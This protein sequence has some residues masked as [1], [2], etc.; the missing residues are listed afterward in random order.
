MSNFLL[1]NFTAIA[2]NNTIPTA[3]GYSVDGSYV[4]NKDSDGN[5]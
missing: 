2:R 4:I 1:T 5:P 3:Q